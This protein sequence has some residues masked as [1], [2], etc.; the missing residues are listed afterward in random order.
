M[1]IGAYRI[2]I[3]F[4]LFKNFFLDP[5]VWILHTNPSKQ[6]LIFKLYKQKCIQTQTTWI[7][8]RKYPPTHVYS[9]QTEKVLTLLIF[10]ESCNFQ[11][12]CCAEHYC[13]GN[14]VAELPMGKQQW[15]GRESI[16]A[17]SMSVVTAG[18]RSLLPMLTADVKT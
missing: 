7:F 1:L 3:K 9:T 16:S 2:W 14:R 4:N 12:L 6:I 11:R 15:V 8:M 17:A 5:Q 18:W 13:Y 10:M